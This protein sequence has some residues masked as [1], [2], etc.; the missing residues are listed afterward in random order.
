[1]EYYTPY[2]H[3]THT[4]QYTIYVMEYAMKHK[5]QFLETRWEITASKQY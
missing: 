3:H 4:T 1:M 2:N 5:K